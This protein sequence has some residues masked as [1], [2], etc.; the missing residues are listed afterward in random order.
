[1]QQPQKYADITLLLEG[2]YPF[3]R[4]GV[5][6]WVHQIIE[7][8]PQYTFSIVFLGSRKSDYGD[9]Q[10]IL[11]DNVVHLECHYLWDPY[12]SSPPKACKGNA[13]Y[14]ENASKLHDWFRSPCLPFDESDLKGLLVSL[15][16]SSGFT[17]EEFYFS[18]A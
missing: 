14:L 6:S 7:G 13:S 8:L 10:Y 16:E 1:M 2:T 18:D 9:P 12:F 3:V 4:G 17:A 11:A 5:S 15:G